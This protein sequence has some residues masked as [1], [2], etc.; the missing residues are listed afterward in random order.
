VKPRV[1]GHAEPAD[2]PGVLRDQGLDEHDVE[3][4]SVGVGYGRNLGAA[5]CRR[6]A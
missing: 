6:R 1:G 5:T 4:G 2:R 3:R